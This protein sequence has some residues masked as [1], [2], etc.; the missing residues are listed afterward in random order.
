MINVFKGP[1]ALATMRTSVVLA[2]RLVLQAG[3]LLL[4]ARILGSSMFGA[5]AGIAALAVML[6][7]LSTFGTHLVLLAET[8]RSFDRRMHVLPY[9]VTTT[10]IA[11]TALCF[12]YCLL[13]RALI[14]PAAIPFHIVVVIG[15]TEV[16]LQPLISL[17]VVQ[18]QAK[19]RIAVS[20]MLTAVP[21]LLRFLV[22]LGIL[23]ARP[24]APLDTYVYGGLVA[25]ILGLVI[26]S[27][28]L[29]AGWPAVRHWRLARFAEL[30][31]AAGFAV[32]NITAAGPTELDKTLAAK[33]LPL[34]TAG[35]YAA[36]ARII[37]ALSLPVIAMVHSALPS[38]FRS[39][40]ERQGIKS[41]M[42]WT[43]YL[44]A[45][46]YGLVVMAAVWAAAPILVWLFGTDYQQLGVVVRW[47]C[48][49]VPGMTVRLASGALLMALGRPWARVAFEVAG[50]TTLTIAA[51][52]LA[53]AAG[54]VGMAIAV[55]CAEWMMTAVGGW[56]VYQNATGPYR[57][58]TS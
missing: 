27:A 18:L 32:L 36:A 4:V 21:L 55:I 22:V 54:V 23:I 17:P 57:P 31:H 12:I 16:V 58:S 2:A 11:G 30:R 40:G 49:A 14:A 56:L 52:L 20:Q 13:V 53:P 15:I 34:G 26:A 41:K 28:A 24:E 47:L 9:S 42:L 44:S 19:R 46:A 38:L 37:A 10:L 5:F 51:A 50:L 8:S 29:D 7:A 6:G 1:I 45:L 3:T 25:V 43:L 39:A 35:V 48:L 33:L